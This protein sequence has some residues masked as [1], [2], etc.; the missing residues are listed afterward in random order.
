[1][2]LFG[3]GT[4]PALLAF[5]LGAARMTPATQ[6]GF[7]TVGAVL[8]LVIGLQLVLRGAAAIGWIDHLRIGG[9]ML[10]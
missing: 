1:M 8:V 3:L 4:V 2:V 5:A 7:R 6:R 9:L 10:W